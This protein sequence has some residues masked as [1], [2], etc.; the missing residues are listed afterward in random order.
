[1]DDEDI[2]GVIYLSDPDPDDDPRRGNVWK[3][4]YQHLRTLRIVESLAVAL[5]EAARRR[6]RKRNANSGHW[7]MPEND[8][9]AVVALF[10]SDL[11]DGL[12][13]NTAPGR[14]AWIIKHGKGI[15]QKTLENWLKKYPEE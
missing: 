8:R 1:M 15:N 2:D 12:V 4:L 7:A 14:D 3:T 6:K 11:A 5:Q 10:R 13:E 9:K